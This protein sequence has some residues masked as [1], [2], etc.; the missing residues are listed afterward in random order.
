MKILRN[1]IKQILKMI[2]QISGNVIYS[3]KKITILNSNE[4][5]FQMIFHQFA[6]IAHSV[7]DWIFRIAEGF[8]PAT[9]TSINS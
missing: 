4:E 1:N 6:V 7:L 8:E 3:Y 9:V 2:L 5:I